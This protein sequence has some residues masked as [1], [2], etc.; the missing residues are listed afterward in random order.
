MINHNKVCD[1]TVKQEDADTDVDIHIV[2]SQREEDTDS[3]QHLN[4]IHWNHEQNDKHPLTIVVDSDTEHFQI[5]IDFVQ[6]LHKAILT[7]VA[8]QSSK[9]WAKEND[10]IISIWQ[11]GRR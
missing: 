1:E 3:Q 6:Q 2:I 8:G 7:C 5:A 9:S 11:D 4:E 10:D